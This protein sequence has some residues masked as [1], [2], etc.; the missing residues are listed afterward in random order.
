LIF[1][2]LAGTKLV[3]G[4]NLLSG[5][6]IRCMT[7]EQLIAFA[8]MLVNTLEF[9]HKAKRF[10][11]LFTSEL[12]TGLPTCREAQIQIE[13]LERMA[14]KFRRKFTIEVILSLPEDKAN[15]IIGAETHRV[16]QQS[17]AVDLVCM[18]L[19]EEKVREFLIEKS[20]IK[21]GGRLPK[22]FLR[23]KTQ[24]FIESRNTLN[25]QECDA[26]MVH[27]LAAAKQ[28]LAALNA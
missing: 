27:T 14:E 25:H 23:M 6:M 3:T 11:A 13:K 2:E 24:K 21:T 16:N 20:I 17:K 22:G 12:F 8:T 18:K 9:S 28:H 4:T 1:P 7:R 15:K 26:A 10:K 5:V 19:I